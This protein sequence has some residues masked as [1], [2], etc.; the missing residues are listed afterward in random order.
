MPDSFD[1]DVDGLPV[2]KAVPVKKKKKAVKKEVK[3][4]AKAQEGKL[5][6]TKDGRMY[7]IVDGKK[8]AVKKK[9]S[10]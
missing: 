2:D 9:N 3:G 1:D 4:K 6:R 5:Y 7:R 8:I 10:A